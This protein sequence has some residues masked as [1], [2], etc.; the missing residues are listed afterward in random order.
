MGKWADAR[1]KAKFNITERKIK[2][3]LSRQFEC[4]VCGRKGNM[5]ALW[6]HSISKDQDCEIWSMQDPISKMKT[7]SMMISFGIPIPENVR[8]DCLQDLLEQMDLMEIL[9]NPDLAA[10]VVVAGLGIFADEEKSQEPS[11]AHDGLP[12]EATW[13]DWDKGT[14]SDQDQERKPQ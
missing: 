1:K 14:K 10:L 12:L 9:N 5:I 4:P 13:N 2:R 7:L 11:P 6:G 3:L 8:S